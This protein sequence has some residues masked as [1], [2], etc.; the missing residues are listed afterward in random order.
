MRQEWFKISY[1]MII[2]LITEVYYTI[3]SAKEY[4]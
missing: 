2:K 3:I 4:R 1:Q